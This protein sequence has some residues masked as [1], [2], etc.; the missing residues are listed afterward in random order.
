MDDVLDTL[1]IIRQYPGVSLFVETGSALCCAGLTTEAM[2]NEIKRKTSLP[3]LSGAC[4]GAGGLMHERIL[5]YLACP[6]PGK[7]AP[8]LTSLSQGAL[9]R[10]EKPGHR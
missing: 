1:C 3:A 4:D 6:Q 8:R 9:Q 5:P 2:V 10:V 7:P